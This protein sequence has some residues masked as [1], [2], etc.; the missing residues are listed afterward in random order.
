MLTYVPA[1]LGALLIVT[2]VAVVFWPAALI[3]AGA[4][5]LV[6]DNRLTAPPKQGKR[7]RIP[8]GDVVR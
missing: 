3:V 6:L 4:F 2:G 1:V 8:K 7:P 5:L